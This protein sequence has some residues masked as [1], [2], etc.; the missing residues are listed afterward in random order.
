[1]MRPAMLAVRPGFR[2]ALDAPFCADDTETS[3]AIA[4]SSTVRDARTVIGTTPLSAPPRRS[5][6]PLLRCVTEDTAVGREK[7][8]GLEGI[9]V[10]D[11]GEVAGDHRPT[12]RLLI[13]R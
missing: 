1:M 7:L 12:H 4:S 8:Y 9:A 11:F 5:V 6:R 2:P 13:A 10:D 3:M